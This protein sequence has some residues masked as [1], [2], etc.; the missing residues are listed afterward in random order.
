MTA[1][2]QSPI[3]R[4]VSASTLDPAEIAKFGKLAAEWWDPNG[5]FAALHRMNPLRLG[6][7]RDRAIEHF[8]VRQPKPLTGL[9]VLDLGCGGGLV[10]TPL[11]RLGANVLGLDGAE[12]AVMAARAYVQEAGLSAKFEVG[13]AEGLAE[14]RAGSFDL[15]TALEVVEHVADLNV[16][17]AA[18][19][20]L[21]KPGGLLVVSTINRTP[22]ARAL[23]LFA[24]EKVLNMA[25]D[26][27][28]EFEKLVTPDELQ[29][30][31][32]ALEW[33]HPIGM[34]FN[35]LLR[36]WSLSSDLSI[37]YLRAATKPAS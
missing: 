27:A 24:A 14:R 25:P 22:Q 21:L 6:F 34:R 33:D 16:F 28:H 3:S 32:P 17:L 31:A 15:I 4:R 23:A 36:S 5:P 12:E 7:A 1:L 20:T 35:P 8:G 30:A 2:R 19:V 9:Q 29:G 10:S 26:G 18:V 11:A 37:N 13:T